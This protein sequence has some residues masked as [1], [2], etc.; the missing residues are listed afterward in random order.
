MKIK[1]ISLFLAFMLVMV[2]WASVPASSETTYTSD[3]DEL[4]CYLLQNSV[5]VD[6]A[7]GSREWADAESMKWWYEPETDHKDAFIYVYAKWDGSNYLYFMIDLCPDNSTEDEDYANWYLD[8]DHDSMFGYDPDYEHYG[9]VN[10]TGVTEIWSFNTPPP[11]S[12]QDYDDLP[13]AMGFGKSDKVAWNH[14][15]IE[16]KVA[17]SYIN[18]S[19]TMG[20]LFMGYGTLSPEYF[21]TE[22]ANS[23]NYDTNDTCANWTDLK[24]KDHTKPVQYYS[25]EMA[26]EVMAVVMFIFLIAIFMIIFSYVRMRK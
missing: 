10:G 13:F 2:I 16:F 25:P 15:I 6:G 1:I 21:S 14:R 11:D 26:S 17:T 8:E 19:S 7:I 9:L 18:Q 22:G 23:T 24:L 5:T 20:I 4:N 3:T 12:Q